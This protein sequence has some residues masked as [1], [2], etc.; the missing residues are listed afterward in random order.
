MRIL[1]EPDPILN[2]PSLPLEP[3]ELKA[4][5]NTARQMAKLMYQADGVGLAAPQV[6]IK[7]R[8]FVVDGDANLELEEDEPRPTSH[9]LF[10]I[11]PRI[12]RLWGKQ[13]EASEGCLS[14]PGINVKV[15]RPTKVEL[16]AL[17]LDGQLF[18]FKAAGFLARAL[19]HEYDHLDGITMFDRLDPITR[20]E[21]LRQYNDRQAAAA[22][23]TA[24]TAD[25]SRS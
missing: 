1:V 7:K 15:K 21:A 22:E 12:I 18:R 16:E 19:Q 11:N 17:D 5:K 9:P 23:G 6:G 24:R 8:M 4:F 25:R 2:E 3:G 20:L 10:F 13:E 14:I